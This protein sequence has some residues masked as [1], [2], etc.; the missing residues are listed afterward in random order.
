MNSSSPDSGPFKLKR[1]S[2][3]LQLV[4]ILAIAGAFPAIAQAD[5]SVTASSSQHGSI[6]PS[7][8]LV[9]SGSSTTFTVIPDP[10]YHVWT[11]SGCGGGL[12]GTTYTTGAVTSDCAVGVIF[13]SD[14]SPSSSTDTWIPT[15]PETA[16]VWSMAIDPKTPTTIYAGTRGGG[17]FK[18]TDSGATWTAANNGLPNFFIKVIAIDPVTPSTL[19]AGTGSSGL[20]KSTDNGQSWQKVGNGLTDNLGNSLTISS[21]AIDPITPSTLYAATNWNIYKST[22]SG[23][24]WTA[25]N[26]G[27]IPAAC[28]ALWSILLPPQRYTQPDAMLY[29]NQ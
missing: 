17:I 23:A 9:T 2:R 29:I 10:G 6:S 24:N 7:S 8:A 22:N 27:L 25:I 14:A 15:G 11:I 1:F 26:T 4:W 18:T 28:M 20:F 16:L 13:V 12:V 21:I 19:Y 5:I 3:V